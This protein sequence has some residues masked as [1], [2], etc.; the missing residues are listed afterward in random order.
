LVKQKFVT[1]AVDARSRDFQDAEGEFVRTSNCVPEGAVAS[2]AVQ[3]MTASGKLLERGEMSADKKTFQASLERAL[4]TWAALPL[5]ERKPGAVK[6]PDRGTVD[7]KRAAGERRP[8]SALIVRVYNRQLGQNAKGELRYTVASDYVP[9]IHQAYPPSSWAARFAEAA[10]DT[11]WVTQSE[12]KA[13]M[14]AN[15]RKDQKIN[16]PTSLCERLFRF[17]LDPARGYGESNNFAN[18]TAKAGKLQLTVEE[19]G[20]NEV[21][22]RLDGHAD[23]QASQYMGTTIVYQPRLL[24]Y[25]AY[26]PTKK[27]FTRFDVVAL[28]DVRGKPVGE[29]AMGQRLG[30]TNLLGIAFELVT[31]PKPADY[32]SP[33]GLRNDGGSFDLARYLGSAKVR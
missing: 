14:P 31:D 22:M 1:V 15:P 17:H 12:W 29:N 9:A 10:H 23:L 21:R 18:V 3:L 7:P 30:D 26:D 19:V 5:A 33:R 4:K 8:D 6:V 11:M 2:G 24:G 27:V 32:L 20:S 16:V 13:M 28:G 25:L